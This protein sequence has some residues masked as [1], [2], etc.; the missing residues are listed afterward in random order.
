MKD[1][2]KKFNTLKKYPKL[3]SHPFM[4]KEANKDYEAIIAPNGE[5]EKQYNSLPYQLTDNQKSDV[6]HPYTNA[7]FVRKY[8]ANFL[9]ELGA[10]K[11]DYDLQSGRT[12]DDSLGDLEHNEYGITLGQRYPLAPKT[13]LFDRVLQYSNLPVPARKNKLYG[14]IDNFP[15]SS[16]DFENFNKQQTK[17][18]FNYLLNPIN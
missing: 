9:R 11:E 13:F 14:Y 12:I 1:I 15:D 3:Y 4:L 18:L 2:T 8:P 6:R 17:K 16:E 7:L 10:F 5:L